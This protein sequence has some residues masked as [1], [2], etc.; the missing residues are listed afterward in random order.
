MAILTQRTVWVRDPSRSRPPNPSLTPEQAQHVLRA[1]RF[2]ATRLGGYRELA[3]QTGY[4]LGQIKN[5]ASGT[6]PPSRKTAT[7]LARVAG[8]DADEL[9]AG[10]WPPAGACAH[11][12]RSD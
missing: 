1:L 3:A 7:R 11:C 6:A 8:K 5:I 12:G 4:C 10:I 2:L 9:I